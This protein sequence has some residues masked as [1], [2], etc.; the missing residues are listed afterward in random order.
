KD[1]AARSAWYFVREADRVESIRPDEGVAEIWRR[2]AGGHIDYEQVYARLARVI[3]YS[4]GQ[5]EA[6]HRTPD[7]TLVST[8]VAS[9]LLDKLERVGSAEV[10]GHTASRH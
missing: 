10:L 8:L 1:A 3:E 5:L 2:G 6:L 9:G 7:W 4:W